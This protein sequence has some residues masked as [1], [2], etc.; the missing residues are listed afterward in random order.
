MIIA[1]L[2]LSAVLAA[3]PEAAAKKADAAIQ[4]I[5]QQIAKAAVDKSSSNW[6]QHLTKPEIATF[7]PARTYYAIMETSKGTIKIKLM[8]DAAPMHVTSLI[9]LARLGFYDGLIFHRVI[10][11]FMAQGGDPLANGT[12]GPGYEYA[13]EFSPKAKHDTPGVLSMANAGPGT[14]GSQFFITFRPTPSLDGKH[15][16]YGKVVDGMDTLKKLEAVGSEGGGTSE[17]LTITKVTIQ[18]D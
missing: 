5:D 6:K 12:G 13:G 11:G 15:T 8:P 10:P 9:Y 1:T 14:D 3:A 16:V 17:K 7:D 4:Q 18:V 2:A